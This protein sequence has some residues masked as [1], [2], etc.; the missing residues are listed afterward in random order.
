MSL[1]WSIGESQRVFA[2][3]WSRL[4]HPRRVREAA[5][6]TPRLFQTKT[7]I[8]W[9]LPWSH[10]ERKLC[11]TWLIASQNQDVRISMSGHR[12]TLK[13]QIIYSYTQKEIVLWV[14]AIV[15][16]YIEENC[17][18][19]LDNW[20]VDRGWWLFQQAIQ[21]ITTD[22]G[23]NLSLSVHYVDTNVKHICHLA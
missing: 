2:T 15:L 7:A 22:R 18:C 14:E 16:R 5:L 13:Q 11:N 9:I 23:L 10:G 19:Q 4:E 12:K 6:L 21:V 8:S 1:D 17:K 20:N 3:W